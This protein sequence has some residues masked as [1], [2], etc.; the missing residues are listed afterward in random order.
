METDRRRTPED[1]S[2]H[3][4]EIADELKM[5]LV[6]EPESLDRVGSAP[7][8]QGTAPAT[9]GSSETM[10]PPIDR[11]KTE[12]SG[13]L[14]PVAIVL[15]ALIGAALL[16]RA[17]LPGVDVPSD[18]RGAV[19]AETPNVPAEIPEQVIEAAPLETEEEEVPS[20]P[21]PPEPEEAEPSDPV[22]DIEEEE[23]APSAP[24]EDEED[25]EDE[26]ERRSRRAMNGKRLS[27]PR[28]AHRYH[29][30]RRP[31]S[32]RP[33]AQERSWREACTRS[34]SPPST[35]PLRQRPAIRL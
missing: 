16:G 25:E 32:R 31:K 19:S 15:L 14:A 33:R 26:E 23:A 30:R 10:E 4:A 11:D 6:T 7:L 5:F 8:A 21:A 28:R 12:K 1:E 35:G 27:R 9:D 18:S 20:Q 13:R 24:E 34:R 22:A 2:R 29:L 17:Y 3:S